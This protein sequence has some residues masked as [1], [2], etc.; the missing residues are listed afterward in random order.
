MVKI[1]KPINKRIKME[2]DRMKQVYEI[3][4]TR[5]IG[6]KVNLRIKEHKAVKEKPSA[7]DMVSNAF[8]FV[9]QMKIDAI[10]NNNPEM[11]SIPYDEWKGYKWNIGD[12]ISITVEPYE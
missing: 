5:R 4:G 12:L 1:T 8:G 10:Q 2:L 9:E 11:I 3:T 7:Q 6:E